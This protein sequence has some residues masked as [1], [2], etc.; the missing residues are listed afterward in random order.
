MALLIDDPPRSWGSLTRAAR[1]LI[2]LGFDSRRVT[3]LLATFASSAQA[4]PALRGHPAVVLPFTDWA[5]RRRLKPDAVREALGGLL[6]EQVE[7]IAVRPLCGPPEGNTRGHAS[8]V[9]D[10][11]LRAG[12]ET[13]LRRVRA[14]GVGCGYFG[15]HALA[16]AARLS[17][18][19]NAIYGLDRGV[20]YEAWPPPESRLAEPLAARH[21]AAV[22]DYV[23]RR[24]QALALQWD[25]G[26]RLL[27]RGAAWQWA[28]R[29][30]GGLFGRLSELGRLLA[31][32][33]V[34]RLL[35]VDAPAVI[36]NHT[37]PAAFA[38]APDGEALVKCDFDLGVFTSDDFICFDPV[39]DLALAAVSAVDPATGDRLRREYEA[40][41]GRAVE[42][43]RWLLH[44]LAHVLVADQ[45]Q[46]PEVRQVDLQPARLLQRY[47]GEVLLSG[48]EPAK[49]GPLCAIDL[50]GVLETTPLG[51]PA[52]SPAGALA[53]RALIRH[54]HRPVL[55]TGRSLDEV[56]DRCAAYGLAGGVAEY[57]SALYLHGSGRVDDLLDPGAREA[58]ERL[59]ATLADAGDVHIDPAYRRSV[60]AFCLDA[61]GRRR[62][63]AGERALE[64][65]AL[66]GTEG[67]LRIVQGYYQSDFIA[68]DS[69]KERA[70]CQLVRELGEDGDPD[71]TLALA[72][73]DTA[74]DLGMLRMARLRV[75]PGNADRTV[76]QASG[77][78]VVRS[79][80]QAGLAEAVAR[81]LGHRPGS[82]AICAPAPLSRSSLLML[83]LLSVQ[84]LGRWRQAGRGLRL[85][86]TSRGPG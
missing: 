32:P 1:D 54:G 84:D 14:R 21:A 65:L 53:L 58:V 77:V 73:G 35:A 75:A 41:T 19:V 69:S 18:R 4:P 11:E 22:A 40:A 74:S 61:R 44:Q 80:A 34:Q 8:A 49:S 78:T 12:G 86:L 43:E 56:R 72:V 51:F 71:S 20:L 66:S 28:A 24:G 82:C 60:R 62:G 30:L 27:Y 67:Q 42:P 33:L 81:L 9:Y 29:P 25:P 5:I 2:G 63:M 26:H 79:R 38:L 85:V 13:S 48:L 3:L 64:A 50:D 39:S 15:E 37:E 10:L 17:G 83:D 36:D 68:S 46:P 57:G 6:G 47:Y 55:A 31:G 59:R 7:V 45:K 23:A 70:L 16:V 52:T 76:K